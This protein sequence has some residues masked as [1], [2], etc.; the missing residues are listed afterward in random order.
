MDTQTE[1]IFAATHESQPT[2]PTFLLRLLTDPLVSG[3]SDASTDSFAISASAFKR[4]Y[5]NIEAGPSCWRMGLELYV[6]SQCSEFRQVYIP[7]IIAKDEPTQLNM[8]FMNHLKNLYKFS[9][10]RIVLWL[11]MRLFWGIVLAVMA[12]GLYAAIV[13]SIVLI[14]VVWSAGFESGSLVKRVVGIGRGWGLVVGGGMRGRNFGNVGRLA[15]GEMVL[16]SVGI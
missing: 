10:P 11:A 16:T 1:F 13:L 7:K 4:A 8:T 5:Y 6:K 15:V 2:P 14:Q 9:L 12:Y 3:L